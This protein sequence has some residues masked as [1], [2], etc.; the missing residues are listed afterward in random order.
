MESAISSPGI[1]NK[2]EQVVLAE[3]SEIVGE[4]SACRVHLTEWEERHLLG[5]R[6]APEKLAEHKKML[7]RLIF[8]CQMFHLGASHPDF[9]DSKL[10]QQLEAILWIFREKLAMFHQPMNSEQADRILQEAF[11]EP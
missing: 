4:L 10:L 7:E 6:P 3:T 9:P 8:F 1:L 11:P 5:E 2:I